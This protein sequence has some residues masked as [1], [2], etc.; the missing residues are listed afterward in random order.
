MGRIA[1][2]TGDTLRKTLLLASLC[3]A[4]AFAA[5]SAIITLEMPVGARQLG[6]GETGVAVAD[7]ATALYYKY[8]KYLNTQH[9]DNSSAVT[10]HAS[11]PEAN[12]SEI[13]PTDKKKPDPVL[14]YL[15]ANDIEYIDQRGPAGC[16]WVIDNKPNMDA[17]LNPLRAAG[18]I[19]V[20]TRDGGEVTNH[21]PAYWTKDS[22]PEFQTEQSADSIASTEPHDRPI[23]LPASTY[24]KTDDQSA[25]EGS[26]GDIISDPVLAY[27]EANKIEYIDRRGRLGCL[28]VI[29]TDPNV[30]ALLNPLRA[31]GMKWSYARD[32]GKST[33]YRPAF[34]TRD[35]SEGLCFE[36]KK[37]TSS[38]G[39]SPIENSV[40]DR[41]LRIKYPKE[42]KLIRK[43][44]FEIAP[45][46]GEGITLSAL[47]D[48]L[49]LQVAYFVSSDI[50]SNAPW[51]ERC[52]NSRYGMALF[53]YVGR[54]SEEE[55]DTA[56]DS[57]RP[58][59]IKESLC[60]TIEYLKSRYSVRLAYDHFETPT[61]YS[62]DMLYKAKNACKDVMWIYYIH[63]RT[64]HY[65]SVETEPE[66][67]ES[68]GHDFSGF[69]SIIKIGNKC[70]KNNYTC[71][72]T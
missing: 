9:D 34:W 38:A 24:S 58:D 60:Q 67:L 20:Y 55:E 22:C 5:N 23:G 27:L 25:N 12:C 71:S 64:S 54:F 4:A 14:T 8:V 52:G 41:R 40:K 11:E 6:M 59:S 19:W 47:Q 30:E 50:L 18:M 48:A 1:F 7:D 43:K 70:C 26:T 61:K 35:S 37:R 29:S 32:G 16:L 15:E 21:R 46:E 31:A 63:S 62:N 44:L 28:W 51:A 33:D 42:Y 56:S 3:S 49:K 72:N 10:A 68:I 53:R 2:P 36:R 65:V 39:E 17:L 45:E 69:K 57:E 13:I 66:Y